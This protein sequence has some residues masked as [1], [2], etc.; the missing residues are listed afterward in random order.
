MH[1]R[2]A[3]LEDVPDIQEIATR[4]WELDYPE[5]VSRETAVDDVRDWYGDDD[6]RTELSRPDASLLVATAGNDVV[7]FVHAIYSAGEGHVM[8]VYV[9]PDARGEGVGR[10]LVDAASDRLFSQ[11][12]DRVRAM[13]L[14]VN[15]PGNEFYEA[16]GFT[17]DEETYETKIGDEFYDERVWVRERED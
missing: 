16:L 8:R 9:D 4:S 12:A 11:G 5:T 7:G 17:L 3:T 13:V 2:A 10:A 14:A 15:E 6:I 1:I